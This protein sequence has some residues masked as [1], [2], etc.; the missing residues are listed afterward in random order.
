[1]TGIV[2]ICL[3]GR[4]EGVKAR[5]TVCGHGN[6]GQGEDGLDDADGIDPG[7]HVE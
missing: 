1:M 7:Q 3:E 5:H 6:R 2:R 4:E